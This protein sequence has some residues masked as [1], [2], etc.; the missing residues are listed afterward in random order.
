[1]SPTDPTPAGT[2]AA[3]YDEAVTALSRAGSP[4]PDLDATLLIE[5]ATGKT[6]LDRLTEP[7]QP[8]SAGQRATLRAA[9]ARRSAHEPV[10]RIIGSR[11]FYGLVLSLGAD[12][13]IPRPD[14]ET[15][16]DLVLPFVRQ[17]IDRN[18]HCR[19]LDLGTGSGAIALALLHAAPGAIATATDIAPGALVV[20]TRNAE[21]LG[22]AARFTPVRSDWFEA[23][24]GQF[25]LI[26]SNPPYI[27]TSA[28]A[29]LEPDVRDHDPML[30][31]DGGRDGLACY[32]RIAAGCRPHL[33]QDGAVAVE[34][35]AGQRTA[36]TDIFAASALSL[37]QSANDLSGRNRVLFFQS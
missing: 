18:G 27:E 6:T 20:A 24:E 12:T 4:T 17:T 2:L 36:V 23:V 25:D 7:T 5:F 22:L 37:T 30:A 10:H 33:A 14:T 29:T 13:L 16:V 15:L 35:G 32:R 3:A 31:L 11:E 28:I 19:I 9:I 26:V 21:A 8:L 34:I 1:M